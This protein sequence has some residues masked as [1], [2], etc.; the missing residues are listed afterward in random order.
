MTRRCRKSRS[1]EAVSKGQ[2]IEQATSAAAKECF[3]GNNLFRAAS[4]RPKKGIDFTVI[5][6]AGVNYRETFGEDAKELAQTPLAAEIR[7]AVEHHEEPLDEVLGTMLS[8]QLPGTEVIDG[9]LNQMRAIRR[10]NEENAV[11]SFNASHTSI[12]EAIKRGSDLAPALTDTALKDIQRARQALSIA[13]TLKEESDL[14]PAFLEKGAVLD[15]LLK[16]DTFFREL[17]HRAVPCR[18]RANRRRL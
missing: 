9:A 17:G 11:L 6:Q 18:H 4:F 10:G 13:P 5:A 3:S 15:D 14:D 8:A 16:R 2:A 1:V 12:K 7:A